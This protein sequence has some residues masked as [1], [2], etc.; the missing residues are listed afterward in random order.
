MAN[1]V[2][3][4]SEFELQLSYYDYFMTNNYIEAMKPIIHHNSRLNCTTAVHLQW[5]LLVG[6][7]FWF[8]AYEPFRDIFMKVCMFGLVWF[9]FMP[10]QPLLVI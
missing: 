4:V 2:V 8:M 5:W 10:Y 1:I 9:V 6:G 3:A 7:L